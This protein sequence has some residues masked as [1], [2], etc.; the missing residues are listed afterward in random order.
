MLKQTCIYNKVLH[1]GC[2]FD[3]STLGEGWDREEK[4]E[5]NGEK[6]GPLTAL[7]VDC[8]NGV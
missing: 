1:W 4:R 7:P 8:L 6:S 2:L 5:K 3:I